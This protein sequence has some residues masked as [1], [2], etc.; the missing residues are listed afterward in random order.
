MKEPHNISL[1]IRVLK[2][3]GGKHALIFLME[4]EKT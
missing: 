3:T 2:D 4:I 1:G